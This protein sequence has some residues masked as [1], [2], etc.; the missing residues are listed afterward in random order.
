MKAAIPQNVKRK[1]FRLSDIQITR[2]SID[3]HPSDDP[4]PDVTAGGDPID[5]CDLVVAAHDSAGN[6]FEVWRGRFEQNGLISESTCV[7]KLVCER[8]WRTEEGP[9]VSCP[10]CLFGGHGA[11]A[12]PKR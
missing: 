2:I 10:I 7:A 1:K 4:F 3:T 6:I 5:W 12:C 11:G 8:T 9:S